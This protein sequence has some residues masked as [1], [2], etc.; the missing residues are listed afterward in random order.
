[1]KNSDSEAKILANRQK[2]PLSA[3]FKELLR[4][5]RIAQ[6]KYIYFAPSL[7]LSFLASCLEGLSIGLLV[8][9]IK[10]MLDSNFAFISKTPVLK[11]IFPLL[12][13]IGSGPN[14][15]A[16]LWLVIF[17][18][19]LALAKNMME[20][21]S[22]LSSARLQRAYVYRLKEQIFSRMLSFGK[23]FYDRSQAMRLWVLTM[24]SPAGLMAQVD[25][26]KDTIG[27]SFL[28]LVYFVIMY[29]ISWQMTLCILLI[30]PILHY[31]SRWLILKI[32]DT[33]SAQ[34]GYN[35]DIGDRVYDLFLCITLVK[36]YAREK[37]EIQWFNR[38]TST[39]EKF[40]Y[41]IIKKQQL[42]GPV[43][44]VITLAGVL[45]LVSVMLLLVQKFKLGSLSG[46]L[47][48]YYVLRKFLSSANVFTSFM[49]SLAAVSVQIEELT[50]LFE[51]KGKFFIPEG[52]EVFAGLKERIE[53]RNLNFSYTPKAKVLEG[54]SFS[55][56]KDKATAI[57][58]PTGSGKTT[59]VSLLMRFYDCPE[60]SVF[61]DG[62]DIRSFTLASLMRH[63]A[64]V[65][66]DTPL[67]STTLKE[68]IVYGLD[69]EISGGEMED[70]L[71][72]SRLYD[73]V[74]KLPAGLDTLIG[75]RGVKLSGGEKQ[76]LALA[77]ALLKGASIIILDEAT[78]SLDSIT[79]AQIQEAIAEAVKGKTAVVIAHR[80]ST[81]K[82]SDKI[83]VIEHGRL[84]E[85]GN[86]QELLEK[87]GSF[88]KY[89]QAQKFD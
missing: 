82:H 8:P 70:I 83:V 62:E 2:M 67:L 59:L 15:S 81:I 76:R 27:K 35:L 54:I 65:A 61:I 7:A 17:I 37:K 72:K 12:P 58:G 51:D 43:Q 40:N 26:I 10:G 24:S 84:S 89:W 75:D 50:F 85:Q 45:I 80:L 16:F 14:V 78:S 18:F 9:L 86:L 39:I 13:Q 87:K 68:N 28:L 1:M 30:F 57:V 63:I 5:F 55:I 77:R 11:H 48:Y 20:Y 6:V 73:L 29:S 34:R 3:N 79:E 60:G 22:A 52:K 56:D 21:F 44:E 31:S 32:K 41:S 4:F 36:S 71:K 49:A 88:Y 64:Y 23:L 53:F 25:R 47:V 19:T 66:Q 38:L 74:A 46:F 69:R 33:V 42:L